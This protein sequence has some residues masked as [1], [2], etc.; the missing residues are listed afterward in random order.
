MNSKY[1][2]NYT[3]KC[4][5]LTIFLFKLLFVLHCKIKCLIVYG[6]DNLYTTIETG[7]DYISKRNMCT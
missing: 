2:T 7:K 4:S 5:K 3:L 6:M 1:E